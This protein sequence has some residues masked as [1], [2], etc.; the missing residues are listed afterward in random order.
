[1][2]YNLPRYG[3]GQVF[4]REEKFSE[5]LAHFQAAAAVN[6]GSSVLACYCGVAAHRMGN[7]K[8]ALAHLSV[9][10]A[11]KAAQGADTG[12]TAR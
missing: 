5:A 9:S 6:P 8:A 2:P 4:L 3:I 10:R 11:R 7:L 12:H 1:M